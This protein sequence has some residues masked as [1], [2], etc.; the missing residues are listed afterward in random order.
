MH[1]RSKVPPQTT[2]AQAGLASIDNDLDRGS[3]GGED[4]ADT[5]QTGKMAA[6]LRVVHDVEDD[7]MSRSDGLRDRSRT[8]SSIVGRGNG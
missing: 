4:F 5:F 7:A 8:S 6:G 3:E 1:P 2:A